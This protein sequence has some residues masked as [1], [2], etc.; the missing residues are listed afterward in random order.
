MTL[1]PDL[2]LRLRG[3]GI[4]TRWLQERTGEKRAECISLLKSL[5]AIQDSMMW[6]LPSLERTR[7]RERR[8]SGNHCGQMKDGDVN[9]RK[10]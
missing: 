7:E 6:R 1:P 2:I 9:G 10:A 8:L 5:G 3:E 4:S